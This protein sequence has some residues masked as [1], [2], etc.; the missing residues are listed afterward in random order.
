MDG[1]LPASCVTR[2]LS[3]IYSPIS[4]PV[5]FWS[6][7]GSLL[8]RESEGVRH[9]EMSVRLCTHDFYP[10]FACLSPLLKFLGGHSKSLKLFKIHHNVVPKRLASAV[11]FRP[12]HHVFDYLLNRVAG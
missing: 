2:R 3:D 10:R 4:S 6:R 8:A 9:R 5:T 12:G 11:Q 1:S 7:C